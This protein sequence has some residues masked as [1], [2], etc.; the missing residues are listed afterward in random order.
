MNNTNGDGSKSTG[1]WWWAMLIVAVLAVPA[2]GIVIAMASG[3]KGFLAV[4]IFIV[5]CWCCTYL[6][7]RLMHKK[8]GSK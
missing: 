1:V 6:G 5:A 2:I 7:M 3:T 4:A 8:M